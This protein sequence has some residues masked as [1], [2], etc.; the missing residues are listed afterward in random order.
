MQTRSMQ[1]GL[2]A[3]V[4][5]MICLTAMQQRNQRQGAPQPGQGPMAGKPA[6]TGQEYNLVPLPQLKEKYKDFDGGLYGGGRNQPPEAHAKAAA[7]A[8]ASIAPLDSE[9]KPS[10]DGKIVLMSIGMSNTTQEFSRFKQIADVDPEKSTKLVIVNAAQGGKDAAAWTNGAS[11]PGRFNNP[12]WDEADRRIKA[13]GVTPR[14]VQV[15]WVKQA[16]IGPARLGEFPDH[17]KVLQ[18]HLETILAL[19][20]AAIPTCAGLPLQPNLRWLRRDPVEPRA[21]FLRERISPCDGPLRTRSRAMP[22]STTTRPR[23]M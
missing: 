21:L 4:L 13:A 22:S 16:L 5:G 11:N 23:A 15:V 19:T 8:A 20:K 6:I 18:G 3:L 14:Q 12:V 10:A 9:G 1:L 2:C 17:A 7:A